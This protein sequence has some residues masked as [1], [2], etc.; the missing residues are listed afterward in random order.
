[1]SSKMTKKSQRLEHNLE[2][3]EEKRLMK[4]M[5][6]EM[7]F[8]LKLKNLERAHR[9]QEYQTQMKL[10]K[11][12]IEE[13]KVNEMRK[14]LES[15]RQSRKSFRFQIAEDMHQIQEG[16]MDV[17][18]MVQKYKELVAQDNLADNGS[19]SPSTRKSLFSESPGRKAPI[20][21]IEEITQR[22]D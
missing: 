1:M 22:S 11:I 5:K 7:E 20:S 6:R 18:K 10:E 4:K 9:S 8:E 12:K 16:S 17:E 13:E 2:A 19:S 3:L 15:Y 14:Q 21:K